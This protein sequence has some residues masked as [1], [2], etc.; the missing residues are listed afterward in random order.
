MITTMI[1][2]DDISPSMLTSLGK[3]ILYEKSDPYVFLCLT[4]GANARNVL[5]PDFVTWNQSRFLQN[6]VTDQ[7]HME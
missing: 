4:E 6:K 2:D 1:D 5:I 3:D 7:R